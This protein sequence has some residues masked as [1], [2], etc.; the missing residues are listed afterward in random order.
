MSP[1]RPR[2][3]TALAALAVSA[4]VIGSSRVV[5]AQG[6]DCF[7]A[8]NAVQ[9][10]ICTDSELIGLDA[11]MASLYRDAVKHA[12]PAE[13]QALASQQQKW[14]TGT[15]DACGQQKDVKGCV[16]GAYASRNAQLTSYASGEATL[17]AGAAGATTSRTSARSAPTPIPPLAPSASPS[18]ASSAVPSPAS[19]SSNASASSSTKKK[20]ASIH[21]TGTHIYSCS[22]QTSLKVTYTKRGR[23]RVQYGS[24]D[25]TLPHV[26][27][28][29]GARYK[30]G[31]TSVWNKGGE[32]LFQHDG[33]KLTC[34]E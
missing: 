30:S 13:Q 34:S 14:A 16:A 17:P 11:K 32:L 23:A 19:S 29:S 1:A 27:S 9:R 7:K 3:K 33:K 22:D 12:T 10:T 28:A 4:T 15:R 5:R 31:A 6:I 2:L 26:K 21:K 25:M 20:S 18:S 8:P 24:S